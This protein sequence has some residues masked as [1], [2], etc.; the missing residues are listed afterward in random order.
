MREALANSAAADRRCLVAEDELAAAT[1]AL[2][3]AEARLMA[4]HFPLQ[5]F[6]DRGSAPQACASVLIRGTNSGDA[7]G[8]E[9]SSSRTA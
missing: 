3:R 8:H 2:E 5:S 4:A 7:Q 1:A 6:A 9:W